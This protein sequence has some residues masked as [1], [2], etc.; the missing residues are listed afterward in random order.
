ML[1][2]TFVSAQT[3][4]AC[5]CLA[6]TAAA[7]PYLNFKAVHLGEKTESV[8]KL[9]GI[10]LNMKKHI[11]LCVKSETTTGSKAL[12]LNVTA[13]FPFI[14]ALWRCLYFVL[15]W[16]DDVLR[17]LND[18][19]SLIITLNTNFF[20]L[21]PRESFVCVQALCLH[22]AFRVTDI[23]KRKESILYNVYTKSG[24][25]NLKLLQLAGGTE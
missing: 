12:N 5:R 16:A 9:R 25:V 17:H 2:Q 13:A 7:A 14:E 21:P 1:H 19:V 20:Q 4:P 23:D 3:V 15:D 10:C 11:Y 22:V 18:S 6:P 8:C 24:P